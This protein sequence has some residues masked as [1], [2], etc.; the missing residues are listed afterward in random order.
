M[1]L[2]KSWVLKEIED[3][4]SGPS[5]WKTLKKYQNKTISLIQESKVFDNSPSFQ[6]PSIFLLKNQCNNHLNSEIEFYQN[7]FG[8]TGFC[9]R[10]TGKYVFD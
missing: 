6:R 3:P 7:S 1:F 10:Y 9:F 8:T 4:N 5:K 2:L